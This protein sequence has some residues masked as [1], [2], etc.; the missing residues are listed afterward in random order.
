MQLSCRQG[1]APNS[2]PRLF[3]EALTYLEVEKGDAWAQGMYEGREMASFRSR[4]RRCGHV[5]ASSL[6]IIR[7]GCYAEP[8]LLAVT[9]A[10]ARLLRREYRE[11]PTGAVLVPAV[12]D[13][14]NVSP[15]RCV[16][17][18]FLISGQLERERERGLTTRRAERRGK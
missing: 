1:V 16:S 2:L 14:L 13:Q 12:N 9:F 3:R 5:Q 10:I 6:A 8:Y 15:G 4:S 7:H 11:E 17:Q 18:Y